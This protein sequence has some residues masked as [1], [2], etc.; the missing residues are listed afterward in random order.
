MTIYFPIQPITHYLTEK[1]KDNFEE[2]VDRE[3]PQHKI[4]D[5]IARTPAFID[6]MTHLERR[7]HDFIRITP[8]KLA[9]FRNF[10]TL[11][12][13][14]ISLIVLFFYEYGYKERP[15]GKFDK[16]ALIDELP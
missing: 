5:L 3:S 16:T 9:F 7:S 4:L 11:L 13:I 14:G 2:N 10:S 12:S 6:E 1:T 15:D 8:K